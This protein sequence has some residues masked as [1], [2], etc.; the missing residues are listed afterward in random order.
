MIK[1]TPTPRELN[2]TEIRCPQHL[3]PLVA[4]FAAAMGITGDTADVDGLHALRAALVAALRRTAQRQRLAPLQE[5]KVTACLASGVTDLIVV[6][7]PV[8]QVEPHNLALM[9]W[10]D[11]PDASAGWRFLL[12]GMRLL[13]VD[14]PSD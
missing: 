7:L 11:G 1:I 5:R 14:A 2:A 8:A 13:A 10:R 12:D 6:P 9:V 4:A 3:R